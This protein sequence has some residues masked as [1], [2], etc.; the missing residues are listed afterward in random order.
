[1]E[2]SS[3]PVTRVN[4]VDQILSRFTSSFSHFELNATRYIRFV[5]ISLC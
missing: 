3:L 2:L 5:Q 1:M 4:S